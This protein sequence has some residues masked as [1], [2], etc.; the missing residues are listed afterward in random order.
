MKMMRIV[1]W[2]AMLTSLL[3][4]TRRNEAAEAGKHYDIHGV[5]VKV[6]PLKKSVTIQHEDVPNF[7]PAMTMPFDVKDEK[8]LNGLKPGERI[9]AD[10]L[11]VSGGDSYLTSITADTKPDTKAKGSAF[12]TSDTAGA[13]NS[14]TTDTVSAASEKSAVATTLFAVKP[15]DEVP[16]IE[17]VDQNGQKHHLSDFRGK[18]LGLTFFFT[19]CPMPSFCPKLAQNFAAAQAELKKS[20]EF[21]SKTQLIAVTI[22]PNYDTPAVLKAYGEKLHIDQNQWLFANAG[23]QATHK[24]SREFGYSAAGKAPDISHNMRTAVIAPDGKLLKMYI[25]SAWR[26]TDFADALRQTLK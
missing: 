17:F 9:R 23:E 18:A 5:V 10:L 25:G 13:K 21:Y 8:I 14:N 2:L 16:D 22:D 1:C 7:M 6:E 20:P 11:Y 24:F 15:G 19:R 12:Q 4:F 3:L 26:P